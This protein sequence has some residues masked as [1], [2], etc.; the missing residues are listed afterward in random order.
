MNNL[1]EKPML[2]HL[3]TKSNS[4]GDLTFFE[5]QVLPFFE[6]K[7]VFWLTAVP[8]RGKRGLHAHIKEKQVLVCLQGTVT[9]R[10][11][12]LSRE[13]LEYK[14]NTA[15]KGLYVPEMHWLEVEF[16]ANSIL[17]VLCD[18][19]F[20]EADYIRDKRAFEDDQRKY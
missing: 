5:N 12:A 17:L 9:V 10:L 15:N 16:S 2:L 18:Q 13:K 1:L 14:L 11:E 3:E 19:E 6:V 20:S 8:D 7:R 4:L